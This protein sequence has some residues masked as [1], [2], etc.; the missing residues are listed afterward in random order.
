MYFQYFIH[1]LWYVGNFPVCC[2]MTDILPAFNLCS[3]PLQCLNVLNLKIV[4]FSID[5]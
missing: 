2:D 1:I 3:D 4:L 5:K